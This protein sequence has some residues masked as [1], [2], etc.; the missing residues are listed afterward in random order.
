MSNSII[1][2]KN[3]V[4]NST[5]NT[6]LLKNANHHLSLQE[7]V[8]ATSKITDH[9]LLEQIIIEKFEILQELPNLPNRDT[10]EQMLLEKSCR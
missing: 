5:K 4:H 10:G 6:L 3:K 2:L 1:F 9:R 8:I 7:V